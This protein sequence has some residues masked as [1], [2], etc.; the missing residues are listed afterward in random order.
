MTYDPNL[1]DNW[2]VVW[3]NGEEC[4][5]QATNARQAKRRAIRKQARILR[6]VGTVPIIYCERYGA[7][8]ER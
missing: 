8:G 7:K 2:K 5:V 4:Y 3:A 1:T 6:P